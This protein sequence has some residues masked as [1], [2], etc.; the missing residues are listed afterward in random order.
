MN[1]DVMPFVRPSSEV[2]QLGSWLLADEGDWRPLPSHLPDWDYQTDLVLQRQVCVD[3]DRLLAESAIPADTEVALVVEWRA[4]AAQL[5]GLAH[6]S[7]VRDSQPATVGT[8]LRGV[9]LAGRLTLTTRLVI[10]ADAGTAQPF[11]ASRAGDVLLEDAAEVQLQGDVS[12]FPIYVVDFTAHNLDPDARW[13]VEIVKDPSHAAAGG[14]RLFLNRDDREIVTAAKRA[15]NPTPVQK[16]LLDWLHTDISRQLVEAALHPDWRDAL[17][18]CADDPDSLGAA[19]SAL[20]FNLFGEPVQ[21]V[22]R[23]RETDPARFA[24]RLQ[25]ALIRISRGGHP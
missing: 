13:H 7:P 25:G 20:L 19:V 16:R 21:A 2:A 8:T 17:P 3:V 6:T 23:M 10:I 18:D 15:V 11:V 9:D 5:A 22:A 12:R 14:V 24:S 4:S 1:T